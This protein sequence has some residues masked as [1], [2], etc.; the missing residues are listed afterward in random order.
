MTN[1]S[2]LRTR[3]QVCLRDPCP[4]FF[5]CVQLPEELSDWSVPYEPIPSAVVRQGTSAFVRVALAK[6]TGLLAAVGAGF[7]LYNGLLASQGERPLSR[8]PGP[9]YQA[10]WDERWP[11]LVLKRRQ[12]S[13]SNGSPGASAGTGGGNVQRLLRTLAAVN[14]PEQLFQVLRV[15]DQ[16]CKQRVVC[17]VHQFLASKGSAGFLL[18]LLSPQVPGMSKY[19]GASAKGLRNE[20][21]AFA[22]RGCP[23]SLGQRLLKIIG[24]R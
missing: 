5:R 4:C 23:D 15:Y 24:L 11:G 12:G 6:V 7:L 21:C 22:F 3:R 19:R 18:T 8:F 14:Y 16:T 2:G 17:E 1:C 20:N 13:S 10:G 9:L